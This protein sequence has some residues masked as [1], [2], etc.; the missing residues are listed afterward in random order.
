MTYTITMPQPVEIK[1]MFDHPRQIHCS[2]LR[3]S[4]SANYQFLEDFKITVDKGISQGK[5]VAVAAKGT[6]LCQIQGA[7][8]RIE[9]SSTSTTHDKKQLIAPRPL[10][11]AL[12]VTEMQLPLSTIAAC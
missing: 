2:L 8:T 10:T 1:S 5:T 6:D 12:E 7:L 4:S 3:R 9:S 11:Y